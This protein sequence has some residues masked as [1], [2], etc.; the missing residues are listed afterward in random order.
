[1]LDRLFSAFILFLIRIGLFL[2]GPIASLF[3]LEKLEAILATATRILLLIIVALIIFFKFKNLIQSYLLLEILFFIFFAFLWRWIYTFAE[4]QKEN[5]F[6]NK[7]NKLS[8][9]D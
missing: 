6:K 1:M 8:R 9:I 5:S 7:I 3:I 4:K 2:I